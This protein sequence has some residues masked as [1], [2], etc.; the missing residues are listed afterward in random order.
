MLDPRNPELPPP[1]PNQRI[2]ED[3]LYRLPAPLLPVLTTP[4]RG[5]ADAQ[6]VGRPQ[7]GAIATRIGKAL[8]Q[9]GTKPVARLEVPR[10]APQHAAEHMARQMRTAYRRADQAH[11]PVEMLPA[12]ILAPRHPA[13][14]SR[15]PQRS[16]GKPAA[17]SQPCAEP[18]RYR[19]WQPARSS[20]RADAR[21]PS[22]CSTTPGPKR[23]KPTA[24]Q[25]HLSAQ[26][27]TE[28]RPAPAHPL[29]ADAACC[30]PQQPV[31][32]ADRRG[33]RT[34]AR[35]ARPGGHPNLVRR[36]S[37]RG[38]KARLQSLRRT[39]AVG[40]PGVP[41]RLVRD[42]IVGL[43]VPNAVGKVHEPDGAQEPDGR[44][45]ACVEIRRERHRHRRAPVPGGIPDDRGQTA[46]RLRLSVPAVLSQSRGSAQPEPGIPAAFGQAGGRSEPQPRLRL[47][48]R[49]RS[50]ARRRSWWRWCT[51]LKAGA[52]S[53]C[54]AVIETR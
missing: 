40:Q 47:C 31:A 52:P 35:R 34:G 32:P 50:F 42:R 20:S 49:S 24:T 22:G 13:V 43:P 48:A 2:H 38:R 27:A 1:V 25:A 7:A 53:V 26:G 18:T 33:L 45:V 44:H 8:H 39:P 46:G 15:N 30:P 11:H 12:L 9:P 16:G 14:S 4:A 37:L 54:A 28:P 19:I 5:L 23:L 10:Q 17:P 3:P 21:A 29:Q 41:S 6:E 51:T 36:R